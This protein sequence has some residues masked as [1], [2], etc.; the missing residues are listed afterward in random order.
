MFIPGSTNRI[1]NLSATT[2]S[3]S[4]TSINNGG[5]SHTKGSWTK[6]LDGATLG[7]AQCDA[8]LVSFGKKL[9]AQSMLVDLAMS[10]A[11]PEYYIF[12]ADMLY[13][14]G[15]ANSD[16]CTYLL[17]VR[18]PIVGSGS[19]DIY[20]RCQQVSTSQT[21]NV[22]VSPIFTG[23]DFG[24]GGRCVTLGAIS[25]SASSGT[26]VD[27]GGTA[28]TKSSYVEFSSSVAIDVRA[29]AIAVGPSTD[30]NRTGTPINI[31]LDVAYG[32]A[33]SE[34]IVIPNHMTS[35]GTTHDFMTNQMIVPVPVS[36]PR[37][38]R[39]AVRSMSNNN[40]VGDRSIEV[41]LYCFGS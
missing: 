26:S 4:G 12:A 33:G 38:S 11:T 10:N 35:F 32:S 2:A 30:F 21:M 39:I 29:I 17:P 1:R 3:S 34:C 14:R 18:L 22:H 40:V 37:G 27:P 36:I 20:A 7:E 5:S 23:I 41:I 8:L 19:N 13:A 31:V 9:N 25:S 15:S 24:S 16:M 6:V 28:N